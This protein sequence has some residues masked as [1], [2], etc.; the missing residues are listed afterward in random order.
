MAHG[1]YRPM[2]AFGGVVGVGGISLYDGTMVLVCRGDKSVEYIF[3][4]RK[5]CP[6]LDRGR[7]A[8]VQ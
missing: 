4:N 7:D 5:E 1:W 2:R 3:Q 6:F 8:I